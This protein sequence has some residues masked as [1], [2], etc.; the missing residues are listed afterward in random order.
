M[1]TKPV[2]WGTNRGSQILSKASIENQFRLLA[3]VQHVKNQWLDLTKDSVGPVNSDGQ[4]CAFHEFRDFSKNLL[5]PTVGDCYWLDVSGLHVSCHFR[6]IYLGIFN[7]FW[8]GFW[9]NGQ[10]LHCFCLLII[11]LNVNV[12]SLAF[13]VSCTCLRVGLLS[14]GHKHMW[15][16]C[17]YIGLETLHLEDRN[18]GFS[19]WAI[20]YT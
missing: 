8:C 6:S 17:D 12:G 7:K 1:N 20:S 9:V 15:C 19:A 11:R 18:F 14:S 16:T 10:L 4:L 2:G 13:L 5:G 3:A